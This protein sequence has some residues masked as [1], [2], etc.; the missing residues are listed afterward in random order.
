MKTKQF[1]HQET[2]FERAKDLQIFGV[3]WEPGLGKSKHVIDTACH[4]FLRDRIQGLLV[5]APNRVHANFLTQEIPVHQWDDVLY[6]GF[7]YDS[8]RAATRRHQGDLESLLTKDPTRLAILVIS[9]D[10][11]K[12]TAGFAAAMK[13]LKTYTS[14]M[15][16]DE[17]TAIA[18]PAAT[19]SK[20]CQLLGP[21]AKYRRVMSGTPVAEG[22]FKI[23]NQ[24]KFLDPNYWKNHGLSSYWVFKQSF[25]LFKPARA[26]QGHQFQQ[27]LGYQNLDYLQKLIKEH[28]SRVL[29][30]DALDLPPKMYS[31]IEF[32]L[33]DKQRKMYDDLID[34]L[35]IEIDNDHTMQA[36]SAL[37]RLTRLQQLISGF[38]VTEETPPWAVG[39]VVIWA[40]PEYTLTGEVVALISDGKQI[41]IEG[42]KPEDIV[43]WQQ[44]V[45]LTD[46][47]LVRLVATKAKTI[48]LF[49]DPQDNPRLQTLVT[50]LE[51]ICHKVIIW[52]RF[53]KDIDLICAQLGDACVRYDGKVGNR[54]RD[55]ALNR[56]RSDDSIRY[57]VAN[58]AALSMGVTLV[59][60]KT[61]VYYSNTFQLEKRLQSED[62]VHRIGQDVSVNII[63]MAARG[64]VDEHIVETLRKKFDLA[65][66]VTGDRL[67]EWIR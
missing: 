17:S 62:R 52:A 55:T 23:F 31:R 14:M 39:D 21:H 16:L 50:I 12:T 25:A 61:V 59:Q 27:L 11:V 5:V 2:D 1:N 10:G 33:D 48:E 15:V 67:R 66:I 22:P 38:A 49:P 8:D 60:A 42:T 9:Y 32:D 13:F 4:L 58:P 44:V 57:F 47:G 64:T 41:I 30:E 45:D 37:V 65:A 20:K 53:T 34:F 24:M 18:E 19:R 54:D 35:R 29:K 28:S 7:V 26:A 36:T 63:D 46:F 3:W 56:F 43:A 6:E 51:P 40:G